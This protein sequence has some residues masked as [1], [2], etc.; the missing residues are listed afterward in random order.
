M[1]AAGEALSGYGNF[2]LLG[3]VSGLVA[4]IGGFLSI[5]YLISRADAAIHQKD[6][7]T[8]IHRVLDSEH[9]KLRESWLAAIQPD[10]NAHLSRAQEILA[11]S[12]S[13]R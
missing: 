11:G 6:L 2:A 9:E 10:I 13:A 12:R 8:E 7:E 1:T 3:S 5:D 4:T